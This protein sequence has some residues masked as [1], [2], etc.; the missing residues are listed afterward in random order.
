MRALSTLSV[1]SLV[2]LAACAGPHTV[3]GAVGADAVTAHVT[4]TGK[5]DTDAL[6]EPI[7]TTFRWDP[8]RLEL[9]M[10]ERLNGIAV[11][12]SKEAGWRDRSAGASSGGALTRSTSG[13][14]LRGVGRGGGGMSSSSGIGGGS[15][16]SGGIGLGPPAPRARRLEADA[17]PTMDGLGGGAGPLR[18]GSTDDNADYGE[19][20]EFLDTWTGRPGVAGNHVPMDVRDRR[21]V[22][23]LGPD[24][25]PVPAARIAIIDRERDEL[26]WNGTTYG[27]GIAPFYPHL[28]GYDGAEGDW[29]VQAEV[30]D[31]ILTRRWDGRA[32]TLTLT[33]DTWPVEATVELDVVFV[34]DTTGSMA[35]EIARIKQT[36]LSV[37]E[38]VRGLD[39]P[40]DLR[41]G[42]VL[43]RDIGD[44]YLTRHTPLTPDVQAF[45]AMLQGIR[46]GGGGD[47]PESLNQGLSMAVG[48]MDWR[49]D[50]AKITFLVADAPP[51]MD[52]QQD[53]TYA[54]AARAALARGIRIHTVAASGLDDFGSLVFRQ[55]AQLTRGEF[56]FIEY[57]ST[58]ASAADHGVTGQVQSNNLDA[59][60]FRKIEAEV[61]GWGSVRM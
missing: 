15:I 10:S 43:Y 61:T 7:R 29:L 32:Q 53:T 39:Q 14:G 25:E 37:T 45:D 11:A 19:F 2:T 13:L 5:D 9:A 35:D 28:A 46:A 6:V 59:I 50:A 56:V 21:F 40:V 24:G 34:I 16:G 51:H 30:G 4:G 49:P 58:A 27:D 1:L 44:E 18:A 12:S 47:G 55:S 8:K 60:L 23:V 22:R 41:Y 33:A 17:A 54:D 48:A 38:R 20:L 52:Y 42:A 57:G 3:E 31:E 26:A 36:L